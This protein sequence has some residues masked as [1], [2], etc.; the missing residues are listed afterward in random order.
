MHPNTYIHS[1]AN[2]HCAIIHPTTQCIHRLSTL[3][4]THNC[5]AGACC[6]CLGVSASVTAGPQRDTKKHLH[7]QTRAL[8]HY[9]QL[10]R[11]HD[12]QTSHRK[13]SCAVTITSGGLEMHAHCSDITVSR[14]FWICSAGNLHRPSAP[15]GRSCCSGVKSAT[16]LR[17]DYVLCQKIVLFPTARPDGASEV[18]NREART[19]GAPDDEE[20]DKTS[21]FNAAS[22][23]LL[24]T[25]PPPPPPTPH[26]R[27][28]GTSSPNRELH[29]SSICAAVASHGPL[30][31]TK[32][33]GEASA[34]RRRRGAQSAKPLH[35]IAV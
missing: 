6:S 1:I 35:L 26:A 11:C 12:M 16:R 27:R 8:L 32:F 30:I 20:Q 17:D 10:W 19:D 22:H 14:G 29:L 33:I 9:R 31:S 25:P 18:Q 24:R 21:F 15:G 5:S 4:S 2:G 23:L 28:N 3:I 7:S 13:G 34:E